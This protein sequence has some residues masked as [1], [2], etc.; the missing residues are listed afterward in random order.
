M[1]ERKITYALNRIRDSREKGYLIEALIRSYLLNID[2][3][4][5]LLHVAEPGLELKGRK[6]KKLVKVFLEELDTQPAL[7]KI[8][9]KRSLKTLKP[10]LLKMDAYFKNLK[11]GSPGPTKTL[12]AESEKIFGI[13]KISANKLIVQG[14]GT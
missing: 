7:K 13:L 5:F 14:S 2:L 8:I 3:I 9:H 1:T 4:R 10:W 12:Q 11:V 6:A